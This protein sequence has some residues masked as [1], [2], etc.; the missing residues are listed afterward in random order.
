MQCTREKRESR[1]EPSSGESAQSTYSTEPS[2]FTARNGVLWL[3]N[4][5]FTTPAHRG[6][7]TTWSSHSI[8][9]RCRASRSQGKIS[10]TRL[11]LAH[12]TAR[13]VAC[14]IKEDRPEAVRFAF[15]HRLPPSRCV[16]WAARGAHTEGC[17]DRERPLQAKPCLPKPA[18]ATRWWP[19][20]RFAAEEGVKRR[21]NTI[22]ATACYTPVCLRARPLRRLS[23]AS[24]E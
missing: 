20:C 4:T 6:A 5:T 1:T 24:P 17:R 9:F 19:Q 8:G 11:G 15:G 14:C 16:R 23:G 7:A 13:P 22:C 10:F 2:C 12:G 18:K 21:D 3:R